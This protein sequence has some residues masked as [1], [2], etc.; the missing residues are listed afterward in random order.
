MA[1]VAPPGA[2]L[3]IRFGMYRTAGTSGEAAGAGIILSWFF[4][5]G[6]KLVVPILALTWILVEEGLDDDL[7]VAITLIG[8]DKAMTDAQ[9]AKLEALPAIK[10]AKQVSFPFKG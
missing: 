1:F 10:R 5:T 6:I 3:A 9:L 7:L 4:T 2:D 8:L